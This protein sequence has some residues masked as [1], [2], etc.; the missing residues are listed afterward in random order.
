VKPLFVDT[1]GWYDLLF[2]GSP[3]HN[4]I[5]DLLRVP[6]VSLVT[7]TYVLDELVALLLTRG[8][9]ATAARVGALIRSAAEVR[10]EHPDAAE[11][12]RA[13]ALFLDS[14]DKTYTLTDCLSFVIMRRLGIE[15]AIATDRHF[16]QEG[17]AT[18]P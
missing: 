12:L 13:W 2:S 15:T 1:S 4:K 5:T 16:R 14:P 10:L 8:D 6:G 7:S 9:H 17:F 3:G 11:E 18:L